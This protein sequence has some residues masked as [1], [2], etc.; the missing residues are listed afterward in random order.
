MPSNTCPCTSAWPSPEKRAAASATR[1]Q[2]KETAWFADKE[3][4]WRP[5]L[6]EFGSKLPEI[7]QRRHHPPPWDGDYGWHLEAILLLPFA[8]LALFGRVLAKVLQGPF[9]IVHF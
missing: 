3:G 7:I 1:S 2:K 4:S 8:I 6:T 5:S 9:D